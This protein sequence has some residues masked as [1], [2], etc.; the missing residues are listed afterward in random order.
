M[1]HRSDMFSFG[2]EK[3]LKEVDFAIENIQAKLGLKNLN[4][5]ESSTPK[6]DV[7]AKT[8]VLTP[9]TPAYKPR[10]SE[11]TGEFNVPFKQSYPSYEDS[12]S[13]IYSNSA[14]SFVLV[15]TAVIAL[16]AMVS[17]V[18]FGILNIINH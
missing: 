14:S 5:V 1:P 17:V 4:V 15:L 18:T 8:R 3:T 12:S 10:V 16:I 7:F 13:S 11:N 2:E 9:E 6:S